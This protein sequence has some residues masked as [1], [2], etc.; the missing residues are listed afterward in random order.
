[1]KASEAFL[2]TYLD[3]LVNCNDMRKFGGVWVQLHAFLT[4][5]L[6]GGAWADSIPSS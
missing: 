1:M 3:S 5:E 2:R 6:N 4:Y